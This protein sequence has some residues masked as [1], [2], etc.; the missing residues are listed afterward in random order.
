VEPVPERIDGAKVLLFTPIDGRHRYTR[1]SWHVVEDVLTCLPHM[2]EDA[3]HAAGLAICRYEGEDGFSLFGCDSAWK[4]ITDT[5]HHTIEEAM[6]QAE[7]A[8]QGVAASWQ[9]LH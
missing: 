2:E 7:S 6:S 8:Y 1:Y 5:W 9:R 3:L 4:I